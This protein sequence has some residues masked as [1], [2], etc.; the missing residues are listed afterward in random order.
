MND[1]VLVSVA[2]IVKQIAH[3]GTDRVGEEV[4]L[5]RL[6]EAG[7]PRAKRRDGH[8]I[9]DDDGVVERGEHAPV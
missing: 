8:E 3:H 4:V 1:S 5:G 9:R 2:T 7:E 6:L